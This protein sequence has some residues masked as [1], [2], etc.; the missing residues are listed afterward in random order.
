MGVI[1]RIKRFISNSVRSAQIA[2]EIREGISNQSSLINNKFIELITGLKRQTEV[3]NTKLN[4]QIDIL[5]AMSQRLGKVEG[6]KPNPSSTEIK[7]GLQAPPKIS[8][9]ENFEQA[10]KELPLM[11]ARKTFNTAHP[12]YDAVEA[13]NFPTTIFNMNSQVNNPLYNELKKLMQ[14]DSIPDYQWD[15][16]LKDTLDEVKT[17]PHADQIFQRKA[18]VETYI[19]ELEA[20]Y[21]AFYRP[22]W[23]NMDDALFL[24]WAVRQLKPN[25]IVQTG[26]CNGLSSAFMMLALVKNGPEGR[27]HVVDMPPVFDSKDPSWKIKNKV[28][29]VVIPEGKDSGW[30]VPDAYRD[31]FEV[32]SGD[33]KLLLPGLLKKLGTVDLFYHDSDH[34]YDHMMFEFEEAKK[35]LT[36]NGVMIGDDISWNASLWDFADQYSVPAYNYKGTMGVACF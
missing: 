35:Y 27:L 16:I 23:V 19:A 6:G 25:V 4:K 3:I 14:G 1:K 2:Q 12:D 24:Y 11:F 9:A 18:F 28:Y 17:V 20:K 21:N 32:L 26:V 30:L 10:M 15:S 7:D 5:E 33:A 34:T 13:R 29:G 22:G 31:R 36:P 8:E